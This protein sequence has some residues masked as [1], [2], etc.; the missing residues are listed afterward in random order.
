VLTRLRLKSSHDRFLACASL[1]TRGR[2][3]FCREGEFRRSHE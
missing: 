2:S 3:A 1:N